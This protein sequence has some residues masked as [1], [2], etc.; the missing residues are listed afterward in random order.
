ME[1][2]RVVKNDDE[3]IDKFDSEIF[4]TLSEPA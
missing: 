2:E 1:E 3:D 4:S